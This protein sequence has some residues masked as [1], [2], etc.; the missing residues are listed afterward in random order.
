MRSQPP[1][2]KALCC[3]CFPREGWLPPFHVH[4][5]AETPGHS[6]SLCQQGAL[7]MASRSTRPGFSL[8]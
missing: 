2:P 8:R 3:E 6:G 4:P 5:L 1:Q 7:Q